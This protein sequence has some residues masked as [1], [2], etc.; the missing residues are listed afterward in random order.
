MTASIHAEQI[1][2]LHNFLWIEINKAVLPVC[3][4]ERANKALNSHLIS[5]RNGSVIIDLSVVREVP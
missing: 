1:Y 5:W 4:D 3:D 2:K